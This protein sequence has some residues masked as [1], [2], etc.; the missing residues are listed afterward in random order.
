MTAGGTNEWIK[1][2]IGCF[3]VL[4]LI[5]V[6][7]VLPQWRPGSGQEGNQQPVPPTPPVGTPILPPAEPGATATPDATVE[8]TVPPPPYTV[9]SVEPLSISL[10]VLDTHTITVSGSG[11][12]QVTEADLEEVD[13]STVI[14]LTVEMPRTDDMITLT[15]GAP[16]FQQGRELGG[17]RRFSLRL[18]KVDVN[19]SVDVRDYI[20]KTTVE[21][22][23]AGSV[24][25]LRPGDTLHLRGDYK[26]GIYPSEKPDIQWVN[27][28]YDVLA[29]GDEVHILK[30]E[31]GWFKIRVVRGATG[32]EGHIY[33]IEKGFVEP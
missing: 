15:I 31:N 20:R 21:N 7:F 23:T 12:D 9:V 16:E 8:S 33:W 14:T 32:A 27:E 13:R 11:L 28:K 29:N 17:E 18:D 1:R 4:G 5:F 30:E 19:Q 6:L 25:D 26:E 3:I 24:R 10:R 22:V 2:V